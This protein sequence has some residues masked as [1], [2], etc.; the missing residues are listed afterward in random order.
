[1]KIPGDELIITSFLVASGLRLFSV[2]FFRVTDL[3]A[4][5]EG[6]DFRGLPFV[7]DGEWIRI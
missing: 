6:E 7:V 1:M 4:G 5:V 2:K 3:M